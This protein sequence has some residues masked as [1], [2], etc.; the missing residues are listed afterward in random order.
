MQYLFRGFMIQVWFGTNFSEI[1][2]H[3][4]NCVL[5]REYTKYYHKYWQHRND[6]YHDEAKQ[7]E[8]I[9]TWYNNEKS[10]ALQSRHIQAR[11]FALHREIN[12]KTSSIKKIRQWILS[13]KRIS[14][15]A[16][17]ME[18]NNIRLYL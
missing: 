15:N 1:K 6:A 3:D 9:L 13:L 4:C 14:K 16:E 2:Y 8:R 17:T 12:T 5:A 11:N 10:N 7:R 18:V